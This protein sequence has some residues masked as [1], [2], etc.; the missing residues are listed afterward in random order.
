MLT[1][2]ENFQPDYWELQI[3]TLD[4][5]TVDSPPRRD[6]LGTFE[7]GHLAV[8]LIFHLARETSFEGG[9]PYIAGSPSYRENVYKIVMYAFFL[10]QE[11]SS[12]LTEAD[13]TNFTSLPF[14]QAFEEII[15]DSVTPPDLILYG[16]IRQRWV[17]IGNRN[18]GL[19]FLWIST[20][21]GF[22]ISTLVGFI[23]LGELKNMI[24]N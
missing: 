2:W 19:G 22:I 6:D 16:I 13:L 17:R 23:F 20:F 24:K 3:G 8:D 12:E 7:S 11:N 18:L 1:Y 10:M 14:E 4:D 5:L 9:F 21:H 15:N